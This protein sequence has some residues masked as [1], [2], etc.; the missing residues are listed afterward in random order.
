MCDVFNRQIKHRIWPPKHGGNG[1]KDERGK[2]DSFALGCIL[3]NTFN[4]HRNINDIVDVDYDYYSFCELLAD[5]QYM[6]PRGLSDA[7]L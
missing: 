3:L 2:Q 6:Y 1:A 5:Q 7:L 4:A